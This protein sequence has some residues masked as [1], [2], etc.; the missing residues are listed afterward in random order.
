[1]TNNW[2]TLQKCSITKNCLHKSG[3]AEF[4]TISI[5][6]WLYPTTIAAVVE[7]RY[8]GHQS[9][10]NWG[11]EGDWGEHAHRNTTGMI[12]LKLLNV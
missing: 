9:A 2:V 6:S 11:E 5:A 7:T 12:I 3:K 10:V 1:M 8:A 4:R